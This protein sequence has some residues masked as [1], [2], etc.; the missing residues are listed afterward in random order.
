[1]RPARWFLLLLVWF[2][3]SCEVPPS[4]ASE[5]L[6]F[7][8]AQAAIAT[9]RAAV[10]TPSSTPTITRTP[11][12]TATTTPTW[13]PSLTGTAT[14]TWTRTPTRTPTSTSTPTLTLTPPPA[15][16]NT[17]ILGC[18]TGVDVTHGMGE[19]TNAYVQVRNTGSTELTNVCLTLS[20]NDEGRVHPDKTHCFSTL[21]PNYQITTK[22]TVDTA[23]KKL[24]AIAVAVTSQQ[25]LADKVSRP[26]CRTM[27]S[28]EVNQTNTILNT[29]RPIQ[30]P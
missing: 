26:D 24:T 5:T 9:A 27:T 4:D 10:K 17:F 25:G 15:K 1:M 22:L 19:V 23:Y 7:Q 30:A 8:T 3:T 28:G 20:A 14:G 11:S 6:V 29:P 2:A 12:L 21:K 18:S 13:T 16:L